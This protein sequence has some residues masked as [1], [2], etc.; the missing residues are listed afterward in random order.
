MPPSPPRTSLDFFFR[1]YVQGNMYI[2]ILYSVLIKKIPA[3]RGGAW[4]KSQADHSATVFTTIGSDKKEIWSFG[5]RNQWLNIQKKSETSCIKAY[6]VL[7]LIEKKSQTTVSYLDGETWPEIYLS[8]NVE[9]EL[10]FKEELQHIQRQFSF[11]PLMSST[12]RTNNLQKVI[13]TR[14]IERSTPLKPESVYIMLY[15]G[16]HSYFVP[17]YVQ[18]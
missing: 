10:S 7:R 15:R 12:T 4:R 16:K 8:E 9:K 17:H 14:T 11:F 2:I 6:S 3:G 1:I 5:Y 13:S 18:T